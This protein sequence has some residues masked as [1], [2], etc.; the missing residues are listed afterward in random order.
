MSY[1]SSFLLHKSFRSPPPPPLLLMLMFKID[2]LV[3]A[4]TLVGS[5]YLA[6]MAS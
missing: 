6:R 4:G 5:T 1:I 2:H 3:Q